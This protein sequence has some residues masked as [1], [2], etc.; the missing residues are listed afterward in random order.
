MSLFWNVLCP[1]TLTTSLTDVLT[2]TG[3]ATADAM[4]G[5]A[6]VLGVRGA[7]RP[8]VFLRGRV[9]VVDVSLPQSAH[10]PGGYESVSARR[11][12]ASP[13]EAMHAGTQRADSFLGCRRRSAGGPHSFQECLRSPFGFFRKTR[14]RSVGDVRSGAGEEFSAPAVGPRSAQSRALPSAPRCVTCSVGTDPP[15]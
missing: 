6:Q 2:R 13:S 3:V 9:R 8:P 1:F 10:L 15:A 4:Q 12:D 11:N 5:G 14:K 7:L